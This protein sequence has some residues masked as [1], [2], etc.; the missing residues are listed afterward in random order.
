MATKQK[1]AGRPAI[2]PQPK[3]G[4]EFIGKTTDAD[5]KHEIVLRKQQA[6]AIEQFGDGLPY[7]RDHYIAEIRR[8]MARTIDAVLSIG[9][10]LIVMKAHEAHG[11]WLGCLRSMGIDDRAAQRMMAAARR[12]DA[13][14]N[15]SPVTHLLKS[16]GAPSKLF[17]MLA[18]PDD[19]LTRIAAG[20]TD[21][22]PDDIESMTRSELSEALREARADKAAL[23]E[24]NA[25]L[26]QTAERAELAAA[27]AKRIWKESSP[28]EQL[29]T[30][31][32]ELDAD[33]LQMSIRMV[34][35]DDKVFSLRKR[36]EALIDH[37]QQHGHD[38]MVYLA[39]VFAQLERY[40]HQVRDEFGIPH[41]AVGDP[42]LEAQ[43]MIT[44]PGKK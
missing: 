16:A 40:L 17:D 24:R 18:L 7:Q 35:Q 39:G 15:A 12:I 42:A 34:S 1:T 37:G 2:K 22:D 38:N 11:E 4:P 13:L 10:R 23:D 28:D 5:A 19:Q 8:D 26:Q 20:D 29:T 43:A 14:P 44:V 25:K 41:L 21:I 32:Q 33:V 27:K 30:L 31:R 6:G 9:R 36:V 3:A